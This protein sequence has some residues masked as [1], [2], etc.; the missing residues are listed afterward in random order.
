V[1]RTA[2]ALLEFRPDG[3]D[4]LWLDHAAGVVGKAILEFGHALGEGV[5][6][7]QAGV[8]LHA[9]GETVAILAI[10]VGEIRN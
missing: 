9:V 2:L 1:G 7:H 4:V 10:A 6:A 8:A 5:S 3:G